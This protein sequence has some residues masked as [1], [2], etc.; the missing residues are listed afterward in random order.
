M[1]TSLAPLMTHVL[2]WTTCPD[3]A[4]ELLTRA[5]FD[6]QAFIGD[7]GQPDDPCY[8][9]YGAGVAEL[10][11]W[12]AAR[13]GY[14]VALDADTVTLKPRRFGRRHEERIYY[15]TPRCA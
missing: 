6:S 11:G 9:P 10:A 12:V 15:V 1:N 3:D 14:P 8:L 5:E 13:L 2:V 7:P 4:W